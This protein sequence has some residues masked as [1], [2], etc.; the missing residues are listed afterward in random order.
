[1]RWGGVNPNG[2]SASK[3]KSVISRLYS[4]LIYNFSTNIL[5][6]TAIIF[7]HFLALVMAH[8]YI[9]FFVLSSS[10]LLSKQTAPIGPLGVKLASTAAAERWI[11]FV[12]L[13]DSWHWCHR[14]EPARPFPIIVHT[15]IVIHTLQ[16]KME[17]DDVVSSGGDDMLKFGLYR[18]T[19]NCLS[20]KSLNPKYVGLSPNSGKKMQIEIEK[21]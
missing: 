12:R 8:S 13:P 16:R 4:T 11:Q 15:D 5:G 10:D 17:Q 20:L 6:R 7:R 3:H 18:N 21:A 14:G 1:M 19:G 9:F 2:I